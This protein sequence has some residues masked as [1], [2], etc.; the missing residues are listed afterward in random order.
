MINVCRFQEHSVILDQNLKFRL[1]KKKQQSAPSWFFLGVDAEFFCD[2][3]GRRS[4]TTFA[5]PSNQISL[6]LT[7][8]EADLIAFNNPGQRPPKALEVIFPWIPPQKYLGNAEDEYNLLI[9]VI[10]KYSAHFISSTN[11][12]NLRWNTVCN[13]VR[14]VNSL[15]ARFYSAWHLPLQDAFVLEET[16][17]DRTVIS[18]D[19]NA[20]YAACMQHMFPNPGALRL[21]KFNRELMPDEPLVPGL[22]RCRLG[23]EIS[24]FIKKYNPFRHFL[25]GRYVGFSL[26]CEISVDLNEF[27]LDFYK[28]HFSKIYIEDAVIT[29]ELI[30]HP[31]ALESRRS[32]SRR[33]NFKS[34]E[35]KVLADREKFHMTL[36]ASSTNRPNKQVHKFSEFKS[37][38][39]F[40]RQRFGI[41]PHQS[42]PVAAVEN[43]L[44]GKKSVSFFRG[45]NNI[46][47]NMPALYDGS[48]CFSL[49]QRIIA[50]SR[51]I[52]LK[53]MEKLNSFASSI[54]ICY[55]NIDS[56]HFSLP[57]NLLPLVFD[58]LLTNVSDKMGDYKIESITANGLW[59]EPGR[60]WLYTKNI[61]KFKN[62]GV[63]DGLNPFKER[64]SYIVIRN[65]EG[66]HIP[67]FA[68]ISMANTLSDS[69]GLMPDSKTGLNRHHFL[70]ISNSFEYKH[71][72]DQFILNRAQVIQHK[73]TAFYKLKKRLKPTLE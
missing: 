21:V 5:C 61:E 64:K 19:Y 11:F 45:K 73:M 29:E 12:C 34:Q 1:K 58:R 69:K 25:S 31:L 26:E 16:R 22:Y 38:L 28:S 55:C 7:Q 65:I 20:M 3:H 9:S 50:R 44:S 56:I 68:S 47:V 13:S 30:V 66:L 57:S 27:E 70:N 2:E 14:M 51:I 6:T 60:Y 23:G 35:N 49:S 15:D 32:F 4:L 67:I 39:N 71:V 8:R 62:K 54:E 48:A 63:S 52:V 59:L 53:Q 18:I 36:M 43:W 42:E 33:K 46:F 40:T 72:L 37:A 41:W 17:P 10:Q 24:Q